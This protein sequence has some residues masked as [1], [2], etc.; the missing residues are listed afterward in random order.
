MGTWFVPAML[1]AHGETE[2]D[3]ARAVAGLLDG[4]ADGPVLEKYVLPNHLAALGSAAH[5]DGD[6]LVY[7]RQ[8]VGAGHW[9]VPFYTNWH[10]GPLPECPTCQGPLFARAMKEDAR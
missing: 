1:I 6:R 5:D 4:H 2:A 9:S 3:A 10:A 7:Q 8:D